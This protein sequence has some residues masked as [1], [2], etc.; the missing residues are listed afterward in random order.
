[1]ETL[2]LFID[3]FESLLKTSSFSMPLASV[4]A[5]SGSA[6]LNW[7]RQHQKEDHTWLEICLFVSD[8]SVTSVIKVVCL[9]RMNTPGMKTEQR[10]R[11]LERIIQFT[12]YTSD[13]S[14]YLHLDTKTS[15]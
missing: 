7:S 1:M 5:D 13:C 12:A 2:I 10:E 14:T 6:G 9:N 4:E 8:A 15:G 3:G 11:G